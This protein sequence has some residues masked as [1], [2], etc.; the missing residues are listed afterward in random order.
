MKKVLPKKAKRISE[1]ILLEVTI[2][3]ESRYVCPESVDNS[4]GKLGFEITR[5]AKP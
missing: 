2:A 5:K 1:L 3:G 4:P